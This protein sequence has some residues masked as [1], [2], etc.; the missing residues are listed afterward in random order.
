MARWHENLFPVCEE[1]DIAYIAFSPMANGFLTGKYNPKTK[2]EG[3]QD[4]RTDMPQYTE[5]GYA[6]AKGL[7]ELLNR[8]AEEKHCTMDFEVSGGHAAK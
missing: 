4:F 5:E 1:P 7:L 8:L 2:F 3:S 6:K